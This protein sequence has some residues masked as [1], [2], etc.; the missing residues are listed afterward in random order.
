MQAV[1]LS[2]SSLILQ[3]TINSFGA[4]AVAGMTVYAKLEGFLY[5]PAFSYGIA[6]TGF[7]GQNYGA[8]RM[9]R[10]KQ[11]VRLSLAVGTGII[12]A[13]SW[14]LLFSCFLVMCTGKVHECH[15]PCA[16]IPRS[17][18]PFLDFWL[19]I[20]HNVSVVEGLC[21]A[22]EREDVGL[23]NYHYP[24]CVGIHCRK[25]WPEAR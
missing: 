14:I 1:F 17:L 25:D 3:V 20:V 11:S 13:L 6:L 16:Q 18:H 4:A 9:D 24:H 23:G 22:A 15:A 5:Y 10:V 12:F 19:V 7:V 2:I 21:A 8:R